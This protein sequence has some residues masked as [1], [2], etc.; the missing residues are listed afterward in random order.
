VSYAALCRIGF[1]TLAL[2]DFDEARRTFRTALERAHASAAI[3]LELLALSGVGA[4]LRATGEP[5]QAATVL[6]FALG[7]EQLPRSYSIAAR[8]ALEA[9]EAEL[10]PEQLAA[11]RHAA[12]ATSLDDLVDQAL[13]VT[14]PN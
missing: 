3:S 10:P 8:P 14:A 4:V 11:A 7:H 1:A 13:A 5:E 2:D 9:L 6:T 12:A